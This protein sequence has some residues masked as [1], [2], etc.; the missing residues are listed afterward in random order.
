MG[1]DGNHF[2]RE[3]PPSMENL[4]KGAKISYQINVA[5]STTRNM[6]K[7]TTNKVFTMNDIVGLERSN[8]R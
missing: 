4:V 6:F 3:V 5:V 2:S 7:A 1:K 8:S